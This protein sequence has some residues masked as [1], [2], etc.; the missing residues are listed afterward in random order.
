MGGGYGLSG[1]CMAY[2]ALFFLAANAMLT[3]DCKVGARDLHER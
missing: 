1:L 3:S 2:G